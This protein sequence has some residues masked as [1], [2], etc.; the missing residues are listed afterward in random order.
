M[1]TQILFNSINSALLLS[2]VAIGFN[3]IFNATKVFHL[4]HAGIYI[5]GI[6]S[7]Y[8]F[9]NLFDK[10]SSI[11]YTVVLP[12]VL[13]IIIVVILI[14]LIEYL[15]YQPLSKLNVNPAISLV[16]SLGV[17]L[18][19]VN[20]ITLIF[21]NEAI[22]ISSNY[23]IFYSN[24]WFKVTD[25]ELIQSLVSL[26]LITCILFLKN[27]RIYKNIRAITYSY[28]VSEKFGINIRQTRL[29]AVIAAS[30]LAAIAGILKVYEVAIDP[31]A[32]MSIILTASVAVIIGGVYSIP[33]TILACFAISLIQNFS[34]KF[35]S[36]QWKDTLTYSLLI[37]VILF[38]QQGLIST[39]QRIETK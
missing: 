26:G 36:A 38:F 5:A 20:V 22:L 10:N 31:N 2:L 34:V 9:R 19:V 1:L 23:S 21:G 16:S 28:L 7:F 33:G 14:S 30:V 3:L 12:F 8:H 17:Y 18:L 32:G 24:R 39:K 27:N 13:T 29:I 37:L 4:A 15:I 25:I 11:I 6:Y 35:L